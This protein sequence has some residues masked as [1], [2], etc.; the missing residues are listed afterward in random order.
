LS[1]APDI[2][3]AEEKGDE[4]DLGVPRTFWVPNASWS[5]KRDGISATLEFIRAL[6]GYIL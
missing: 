3:H 1:P 6:I 4:P 5:V 2:Q